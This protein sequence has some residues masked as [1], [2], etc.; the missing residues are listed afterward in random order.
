[1]QYKLI[2]ESPRSKVALRIA[3][4]G[5]TYAGLA[6]QENSN[7][8]IEEQLVQAMRKGVL[9]EGIEGTEFSR[10]GRTDKGVSAAGQVVALFLRDNHS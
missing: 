3:Y 5:R 7:N 10:S 9:I 8:T 1:M 6:I 2:R 4:D